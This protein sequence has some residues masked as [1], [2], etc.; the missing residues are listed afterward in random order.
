MN[1]I[2]QEQKIDLQDTPIENIFITDYMPLAD[3]TYVKVYLMGYKFATDK[4]KKNNFNNE[5]IAKNL[6]IPLADV[7]N[8]WTFWETQGIIIKH[9]TEDEYNYNVEFVNLK[10][11]YID[12][13]YRHLPN[14]T[15]EDDNISYDTSIKSVSN[16]EL[17]N[18]NKMTDMKK[19]HEEIDKIFG[20]PQNINNKKKILK[21]QK[22]YELS[23]EMMVQAFSYCIN[24][25]KIRRYSYIESIISMWHNENITDMDTLSE[26]LENR[27]DRYFIYS[28]ISKALGF[29]NRVLTEG[30]R[31]TIDK[32]VDDFQF[33]IDMILKGLD[34]STKISNP[35]IN[36]FDAILEN[37]HKKGYKKP[38]DVVND[39]KVVKKKVTSKQVVTTEKKNKFHNFEQRTDQYTPEELKEIGK[40][41][42]ER[43]LKELGLNM[44]SEDKI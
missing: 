2:L 19:M 20:E 22:Q 34:N 30:E 25:K 12:K 4:E 39:K 26:F 17:L 11:L 13:I 31:K 21:W 37:W 27:E 7:L 3:G 14:A 23:P 28:R 40:R 18:S 9:E 5:T 36:Y 15:K 38:E 35:N 16:K 6:K 32:W 10:Q 44:Q 29:N 41:N 33:S 24:N 42:F 43:K 8:A 1:F